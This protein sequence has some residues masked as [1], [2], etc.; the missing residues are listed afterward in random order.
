MLAAVCVAVLAAGCSDLRIRRAED[1][2]PPLT[3]GEARL[4][5]VNEGA[6]PAAVELTHEEPEL[7]TFAAELPPGEPMVLTVP[8]GR[9]RGIER[10]RLGAGVSGVHRGR[11]KF[12]EGDCYEWRVGK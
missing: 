8:P 11:V 1:I 7:F 4:L 2:P 6:A 10:F 12:Q 3:L 5:I 9:Y